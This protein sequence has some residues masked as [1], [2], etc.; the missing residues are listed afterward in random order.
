MRRMVRITTAT[1][2]CGAL[3][4]AWLAWSVPSREI[5]AE[6]PPVRAQPAAPTQDL[7]ADSM[8]EEL[9]R[10]A[11]FRATRHLATVAFG[12]DTA[13]GTPA[14]AP[15]QLRPTLYLAG[16][17]WAKVPLAVLAGAPGVAGTRALGVRDTIAGLT[18]AR[19]SRKGVVIVGYDT[20]WTLAVRPEWQ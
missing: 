10:I 4:L 11:P 16:V 6:S 20:T 8:A 9:I 17:V 13:T 7:N 19:I 2:M 15:P 18:V 1:L 12:S 3:A 14:S 5:R